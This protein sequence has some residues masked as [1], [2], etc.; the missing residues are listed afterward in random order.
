M[1]TGRNSYPGDLATGTAGNLMINRRPKTGFKQYTFNLKYLRV[2]L[3]ASNDRLWG[4][5]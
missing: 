3:T 1:D 2:H 5:F 4:I